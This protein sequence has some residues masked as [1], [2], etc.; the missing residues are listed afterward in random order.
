MDVREV[1]VVDWGNSKQ[2]EE[3][4]CRDSWT[5]RQ[6]WQEKNGSR[7]KEQV[8][9]NGWM[10]R[11]VGGWMDGREVEVAGCRDSKQRRM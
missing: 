8:G 2:A 3:N 5:V 9:R 11:W 7:N 1:D 10:N 4:V 6:G